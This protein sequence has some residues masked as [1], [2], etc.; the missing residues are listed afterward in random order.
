MKNEQLK[1]IKILEELIDYF[2]RNGSYD[3]N[4]ALKYHKDKI[5]IH[6][7]GTCEHRPADFMELY[8]LLNSARRPEL[9]GYYYELLGSSVGNGELKLLGSL[10]DRADMSYENNLLSVTVFRYLTGKGS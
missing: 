2:F 3:L 5:C 6:V 7:E 4:M 8:E 9:E 10:I 1:A